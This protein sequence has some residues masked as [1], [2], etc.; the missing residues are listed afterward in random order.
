[1][2]KWPPSQN[3]DDDD[4]WLLLYAI[5]KLKSVSLLYD[6]SMKLLNYF[7]LQLLL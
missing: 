7:N 2:E 5:T 4:D 6:S 3:D 1:M